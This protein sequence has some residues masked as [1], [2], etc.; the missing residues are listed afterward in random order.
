[1]VS[2]CVQRSGEEAV[3]S[4]ML[5]EMHRFKDRQRWD[6]TMND[7]FGDDSWVAAVAAGGGDEGRTKNA[8]VRAYQDRFEQAGCVTARF[9][10]RVS[11]RTPRYALILI[12]RHPASLKCWNPVAWNLDPNRGVGAAVQGELE[13][14]PDLSQLRMALAGLAGQELAWPELQRL[15]LTAGF[16]PAHLRRALTLLALAGNAVRTAPAA[17]ASPWPDTSTVRFFDDDVEDV[18]DTKPFDVDS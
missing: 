13:F 15:A 1:M 11:N 3:V 2:A 5:D 12:S 17:A 6:E 9:D 7:V 10:V 14:G 8:L 16:T 4:L 18:D